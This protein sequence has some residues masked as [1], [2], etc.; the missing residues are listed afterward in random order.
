[1]GATYW[2]VDKNVNISLLETPIEMKKIYENNSYAVVELPKC[3]K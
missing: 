1:M 3:E 2:L